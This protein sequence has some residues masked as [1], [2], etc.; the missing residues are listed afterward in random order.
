MPDTMFR[1]GGYELKISED[2]QRWY[3]RTVGGARAGWSVWRQPMVSPRET[4][5]AVVLRVL[6]ELEHVRL[7]MQARKV[8]SDPLPCGHPAACL[9]IEQ[10]RE[11]PVEAH[12]CEWCAELKEK[13]AEAACWRA[14]RDAL[15]E[16]QPDWS[17]A[18]VASDPG[19]AATWTL[20]GW[21]RQA[22]EWRV[23]R[24][25]LNELD[26]DWTRRAENP[27]EAAGLTLRAWD[28]QAAQSNEDRCEAQAD[29]ARLVAL[30]DRQTRLLSDV[31]SLKR[32]WDAFARS[33]A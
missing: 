30:E 27:G 25:T 7:D 33:R 19:E 16:L 29:H 8:A 21:C 9:Q 26:P 10:D 4:V 12:G 18:T 22:A 23:V 11:A 3:F 6:L 2:R 20:R 32:E 31:N 15:T 13:D 24:D 14:V 17:A 1:V 28:Q 5:D